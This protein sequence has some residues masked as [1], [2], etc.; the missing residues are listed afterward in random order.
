VV[1]IDDARLFIGQRDYPT[2]EEL[3]TFI[4]MQNQGYSMNVDSDIILLTPDL[5]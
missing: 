4:K 2:M 1:L 5:C 3:D